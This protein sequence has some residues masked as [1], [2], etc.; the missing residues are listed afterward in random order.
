ME[1]VPKKRN[2]KINMEKT[3]IMILGGEES[4]ETDVG[5]IKLKQ[6]KSLKCLGVQI[7]KNAK[8]EAEINER[9]STAKKMYYTPNRNVLRLRANTKNTGVNV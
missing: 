8:Q 5:S 1:R 3:T 2:M 6:V 9:I 4:V 7:H